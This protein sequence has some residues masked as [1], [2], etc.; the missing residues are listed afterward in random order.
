MNVKKVAVVAIKHPEFDN[1]FLH[2]RRRDNKKWTIPGGGFEKEENAKECAVRELQEETGLKCKNMKYWGCKK[3]EE[4]NKKIEVHL[5][6]ADC[7]KSLDLCVE[8]DP[9]QEMVHFKFLDPKTHKDLH[10]PIN[11]NILLDYLNEK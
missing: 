11:R 7:P 1:L 10:I 9:D 5:F 6:I 4:K 2:G 3:V 8:D